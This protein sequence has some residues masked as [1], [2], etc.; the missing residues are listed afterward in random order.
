M[1]SLNLKPTIPKTE[2]DR[3]DLMMKDIESACQWSVDRTDL[4][5]NQLGLYDKAVLFMMSFK[6][7]ITSPFRR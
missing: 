6:E 4:K 2:L 3:R 7:R 5:D 1:Q